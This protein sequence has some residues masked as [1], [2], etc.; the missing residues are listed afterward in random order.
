MKNMRM[1]TVTGLVDEQSGVLYVAA[2][3]PGRHEAVDIDESTA[4]D[5]YVLTRFTGHFDAENADDAARVAAGLVRQFAED[6]SAA[7]HPE[8][9]RH[10]GRD[11]ENID[12]RGLL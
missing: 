8:P 1:Y 4:V 9:N 5:G 11:V 10:G 3:L 12:P 7:W 2:V 6:Q